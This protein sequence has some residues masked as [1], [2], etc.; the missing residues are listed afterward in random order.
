[1]GFGENVAKIQ[2]GTVDR[3][4]ELP[5]FILHSILSN[6]DTKEVGRTS[7]LSKRWYEAWSSVPVLNFRLEDY[8]EYWDSSEKYGFSFDDDVI[9]SYLG[10]IDRTMQRYD[11]HKYRI[12]KLDLEL[13]T[14]DKKIEPLVDKW[15]K[16]AVQNQ[17]EN[18]SIG[19]ISPYSP[20]SPHTSESSDYR[21]PEILFRAKS[22]KRLYCRDAVLPYYETMELISLED[23]TLVLENVD[24][25][26]LQRIITF[27]PLVE[28]TTIS[29]LGKI[30]LPWPRNMN[31]VMQSQF[32][33]SP[34]R[35]LVY[36]GVYRVVKW[37]FNMNVVAL[38]NLR[39]LDISSAI[40]TDDIVSELAS[41]LV[42]LESLVLDSCSML[43]CIMISSISLKELRIIE[44]FNL[45]KVTIDAPNLIEF[46]CKCEVGTSLSLIRVSDHCNAQFSPLVNMMTDFTTTDWLIKLKKIL[47]ETK[48]FQS[49]VIQL[50]NSLEIGPVAVEE[51]ELRNVVAGPPYKL[52]ELKVQES[53]AFDWVEFLI[54]ALE[55]L[56]LIC[57]PDS[58]SI[59]TSSQDF[60]AEW[61]LDRLKLKV[62]RWKHPLKSIEVE[63]IDRSGLLSYRQQI[64]YT[65]R[66]SWLDL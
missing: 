63:G 35:K 59:T 40:I 21:L 45:M 10:F 52:R 38:K 13:P 24:I 42:A 62:Q 34:L 28:F 25:D 47:K 58:V 65:F 37:P 1:M 43:K 3:I 60:S 64:E 4:S 56:F 15:I 50:P 49:L 57:H 17:V 14:A 36:R 22:L 41:G 46:V 54:M 27:C 44:V 19:T 2:R 51:E 31:E 53:Y 7:V 66:L 33:A 55:G 9:Q 32:K 39:E 30:S 8:K 48:S 18:L 16:I 20:E 23:L 61:V 12:R 11:T 6:L 29:D 5:E 26:M